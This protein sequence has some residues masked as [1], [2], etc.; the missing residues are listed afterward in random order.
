MGLY[1]VKVTEYLNEIQVTYYDYSISKGAGEDDK[2]SKQYS[3]DSEQPIKDNKQDIKS[4]DEK[5]ENKKRSTRRSKQGIYELARSNKWEWFATFTFSNDRY[6]YIK[7]KDKLRKW[8]SNTKERKCNNLEWLCVPER[9]KDGAF[10][11]HA[12]LKGELEPIIDF[13][14]WNEEK[15]VF[16]NYKLGIA[17]LERVKDTNRVS[18]YITKYITKDLLGDIKDARRYFY[19]KG[20]KKP[21]VKE[22][23]TN[24]SLIEFLEN[25]MADKNIVYSNNAEYKG[26]LIQ[27]IQ[28]KEA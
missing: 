5:I 6:D 23:Y 28:L 17:E 26:H 3:N 8:L 20:V 27:Y 19:S 14:G 2:A 21:I 4:S 24:D 9:H 15:F 7:C 10:H 25:N 12:L 16:T 11:F 18:M 13:K 1:N 22:F